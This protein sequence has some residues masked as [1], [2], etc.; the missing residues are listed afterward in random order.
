[1]VDSIKKKKKKSFPYGDNDGK[2]KPED[3]INNN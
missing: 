1:M 2:I 3:L